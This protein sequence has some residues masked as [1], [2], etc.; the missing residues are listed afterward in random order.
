MT[1]IVIRALIAAGA[2]A[3]F[4]QGQSTTGRIVGVVADASQAVLPAAE[5]RIENLDT[6]AA[7]KVLTGAEGTYTATNLA[8]GRYNVIV[9][10]A[11]FKRTMQG[12]VTL[13][14]NQTVRVDF[15]L[16]PGNVTESIT[17][18]SEVP[19]VQTEDS[20]LGTVVDN[21]TMVQLPLNGRNFIRLGS[22]MAGTTQGAPGNTVQ[23]DRQEGE[24]LTANGQRAEY[25]N[26]MLDGADNNETLFGVALLVP[27]IDAIQEFKVQT[28][29]YS[30]E[31]GRAAGAIINVSIKSGTNE[32]HGTGSNSSGTTPSMLPASSPTMPAGQRLLCVI[33]SSAFPPG[34]PSS[35]TNCS[36]L[37]T[38]EASVSGVRVCPDFRFRQRSSGPETSLVSPLCSTR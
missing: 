31:F 2:C 19:V 15:A 36:S 21:R 14:I 11:G 37:E 22:L 23:R 26:Y 38:T 34:E 30:A 4:V 28:G 1:R 24:A 35:G 25:N 29:N 7:R 3:V 33:T 5:V 13:E 9:E 10:H 18:R 6:G 27:S 16:E 32:L 12:P 8:V 17:V 20:S